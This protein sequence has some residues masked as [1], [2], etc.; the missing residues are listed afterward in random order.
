MNRILSA[1]TAVASAL[2]VPFDPTVLSE[3]LVVARNIF[4]L[5]DSAPYEAAGTTFLVLEEI[6]TFTNQ[7]YLSTLGYVLVDPEYAD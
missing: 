4:E 3:S 5:L 6:K 1:S 7:E 2:K